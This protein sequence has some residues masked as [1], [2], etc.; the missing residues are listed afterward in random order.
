MHVRQPCE[1][2]AS[3]WRGALTFWWP[4]WALSSLARWAQAAAMWACSRRITGS[5]SYPNSSC[6]RPSCSKDSPLPATGK[7]WRSE[8]LQ[9]PVCVC[10]CVS[11]CLCV[12]QRLS[13]A[14]DRLPEQEEKTKIFEV[15]CVLDT[16]RLGCVLNLGVS[17]WGW[18]KWVD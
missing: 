15:G 2:A 1:H 12:Q 14:C 9:L 3:T 7:A 17:C 5:T 10:L 8:T 16:H 18:G 6:S 11:V 4:L 13:S